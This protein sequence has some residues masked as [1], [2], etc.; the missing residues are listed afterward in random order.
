MKARRATLALF[1]IGDFVLQFG[2][3]IIGIADPGAGVLHLFRII[4]L[5]PLSLVPSRLW[6]WLPSISL[7]G[8]VNSGLYTFLGALLVNTLIWTMF[9]NLC[10]MA[11]SSGRQSV[12]R[13]S[14]N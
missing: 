3:S 8:A 6:T 10:L 14:S 1:A 4:V 7:Q 2:A 12:H 11:V 13:L 9:F 5:A